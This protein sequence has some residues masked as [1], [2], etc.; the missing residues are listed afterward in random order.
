MTK[1]QNMKTI[2]IF[3]GPNLNLLGQR[4][5]D[6]YGHTTLSDIENTLQVLAGELGVEI[7]CAQ[8]NGEG[9][10]L[11]ALHATL[12]DENIGG[13]VLNAGAWTHYSYALRDAIAAIRVPVVEVHLSNT[14][15]RESWRHH[16]VISAV[17]RG[18]IQG[19]GPLS[20]E[21][22]LRAIVQVLATE[23]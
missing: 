8:F 18:T 17:C 1:N 6:I 5:P 4:E 11:S 20:Y 23:N 7:R 13:V 9:D 22:G 16:S 15:A 2:G 12:D 14:A 3:H 10:L 19:F 21:L